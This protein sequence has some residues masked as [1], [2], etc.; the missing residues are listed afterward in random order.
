M[1]TGSDV[2]NYL[3]SMQYDQTS[4]LYTGDMDAL[5]ISLKRFM[6]QKGWL[7][8]LLSL[9]QNLI[10]PVLTLGLIHATLTLLRGGTATVSTVFSRVG[11]IIRV[12]AL[13]I[14]IGLKVLLWMLPGLAVA[15]LAIVIGILT[16]KAGV[17]LALYFVSMMVMT[18]PMIMA[19]YRYAMASTFLADEP[20]TGVLTCI[21]R[22]KEVMKNRKMQ[23]FTLEFP[24]AAGNW[25]ASTL[26][27]M[28]LGTVIGATIGM[29]LQLILTVY[30]MGAQCAFF[31]AYSRPEGG[32]AHAFQA[33]PYHMDMDE[34]KE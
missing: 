1:L 8:G 9:V 14:V 23:L 18:V 33:D 17:M 3:M 11:S 20:E 5:M 25:L 6:G 21:R 30:L 10:S 19:V 15:V 12:I 27:V 32:R 7:S 2:M 13:N 28:L 22:S 24:Y 34:M 16:E 26:P 29:M 31:E 4:P